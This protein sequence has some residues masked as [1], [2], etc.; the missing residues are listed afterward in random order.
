MKI[1]IKKL[2]EDAIIPSYAHKND[3]GMDLCSIDEVEIAPGET[4]L[5]HTGISIELPSAT[6]A[7][8][9]PRSGLALK[10][11]ITI[12]NT[13]GTIDEGYRGEIGVILINHGKTSFHIRKGMRI[14]QMVIKPVI[15]VDVE[16]VDELAQTLRNEGGFGSTGLS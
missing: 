8:I 6:E 12:L 16:E 15:F 5:I 4:Q 11:S 7:Q 2:S 1:K 14:A 13:P 3:A 10:H 9:R